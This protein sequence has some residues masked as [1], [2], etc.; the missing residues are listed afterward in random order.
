MSSTSHGAT[1]YYFVPSP[2]SYPALAAAGLFFMALGAGQWI[3][4]SVED[5]DDLA[6]G[7]AGGFGHK[8]IAT[9]HATLAAQ[10]AAVFEGQ[11][12]L[13]QVRLGETGSLGDVADRRRS[14]AAVQ[15][16][17][18]QG[19]TRIVAAGGDLHG[20]HRRHWS[21]PW[22]VRG[23]ARSEHA[24]SPVLPAAGRDEGFGRNCARVRHYR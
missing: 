14:V 12:D 19:A 7:D 22:R 24:V 18:E 5:R 4:R 15:R 10:Q 3:K 6:E 8:L 16:Q 9:A 17:R 13:L 21:G 20:V 2:S 11:E 1:P 23:G